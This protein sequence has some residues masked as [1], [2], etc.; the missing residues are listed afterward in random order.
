MPGSITD[1][2]KAR[3]GKRPERNGRGIM[4]SPMDMEETT[5]TRRIDRPVPRRRMVNRTAYLAAGS[6]CLV[7]LGGLVF[8]NYHPASASRQV[9]PLPQG[10]KLDGVVTAVAPQQ[11][12]LE[13]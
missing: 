10:G 1:T 4:T 8:A 2:I 9:L 11:G 5:V 7:A 6:A 12:R 3:G 13:I